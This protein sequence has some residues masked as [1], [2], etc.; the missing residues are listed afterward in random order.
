MMDAR[1]HALWQADLEHVAAGDYPRELLFQL[2]ARSYLRA[3]PSIARDLPLVARRMKKGNFQDLPADLDAE[4]YP[5]Y[6]RRNFHWQTDGWFSASS[7]A[8]YDATVEMLFGGAADVMRRMAIPPLTRALRDKAA[9][10]VLDVASGTGRF[11]SQLHTAL[12]RAR[13]VGIDLSVPYCAHARRA[14]AHVPDLAIVADNAEKM[15][16]ADDLFDAVSSVFLF[17]ELPKDAR[18]NVMRE[19]HRV[20]A[21]GGLV[22]VNDSAQ[23][24]DSPQ[25]ARMLA[26][27]PEGYHEPYYKGYIHDPLEDA[28]RETGFEVLSSQVAMV[29][30]VVVARKS[31]VAAE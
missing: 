16:F 14:L 17:H 22:V 9:P 4:R 10:R 15:P 29:S 12:P 30:K 23:L 2:P 24:N 21:P 7:A 3:V 6:Y 18:R 31:H 8:R 25:L 26:G 13:L 11:L 28:L 1:L 27:F 19:M 20:V 5:A